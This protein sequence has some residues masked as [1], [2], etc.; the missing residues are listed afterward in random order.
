MALLIHHTIKMRLAYSLTLTLVSWLS[1]PTSAVPVFSKPLGDIKE[2]ALG[3][4]NPTPVLHADSSLPLEHPQEEDCDIVGSFLLQCANEVLD[5][6]NKNYNEIFENRWRHASKMEKI[7]DAPR[8]SFTIERACFFQMIE[9]MFELRASYFTKYSQADKLESD[10]MLKRPELSPKF[11]EILEK[12]DSI[13]RKAFPQGRLIGYAEYK[14]KHNDVSIQF[15]LAFL[16][17]AF[18]SLEW[19]IP[20]D[21]HIKI[22]DPSVQLQNIHMRAARLSLWHFKVR[23][24][25]NTKRRILEERKLELAMSG[26]YKYKL[27]FHF[28]LRS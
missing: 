23:P 2:T 9:L 8:R 12:I 4:A 19:P 27:I 14:R 25:P 6:F 22:N 15:R 28:D 20:E 17:H 7:T 21:T 10:E 11:Y 24:V 18:R 26:T 1:S 5:C 13:C 16:A 3:A